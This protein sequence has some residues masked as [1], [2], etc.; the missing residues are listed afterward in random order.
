MIE[1][2][3]NQHAKILEKHGDEIQQLKL[4]VNNYDALQSDHCNK[5]DNFDERIRINETKVAVFESKLNTTNK[6][7]MAIF[8]V[9]LGATCAMVYELLIKGVTK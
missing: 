6:I 5:I 1:E 9:I 3:V 8:T 2:R 4:E 7:L